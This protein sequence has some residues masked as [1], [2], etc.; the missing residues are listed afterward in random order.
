MPHHT[1]FNERPECQDRLIQFLV[2]MGY[3]Y[4]PRGEAEKKRAS[5]S[6][7]VFEDEVINFLKKQTYTFKN[8]EYH[9]SGESIR[10]AV[11]GLDVSLL[12]GL[13]LAGKEIYHMLTLGV[14]VEENIVVDRD[15]PIRQSFDLSFIDFE[16]PL[17]NTWQVTE[18][19]SVERPNGSFARPDIV[20]LVNGIP[21]VVIECKKSG[22]DVLAGVKQNIRNMQPDYI[23]QLF[24]FAQIVLALNPNKGLYGTSGSG[25][26][27]FIEWKEENLEW[28]KELCQ[29][30]SPDREILEQDRVATSLLEKT[31]LL[32]II[33]HFILYDSNIKK[34]VRHQQYFAIHAAIK[35]IDGSDGKGSEETH[36]GGVIWHTQ[37][38]GKSL[39]MIMLVKMI[40]A[41]KGME[42]PRFLMVTDRVNLDKQIKENFV[43]SAMV[44]SHAATGKGLKGLLQDKSNT[45]ITTLL[46]KFVTVCKN[47]Y[48]AVDSDKFYIFV[49]EAHRSQ[50]SS[51]Y[52]YM[53]EV[54]PNATIIGFTGTPLI[55][56]KKKN[57][58]A[59]FGAGIHSYTM[60]KGIEDKIIVPLVYEGRVVVQNNPQSTIDGFFD[61]MTKDLPKEHQDMLKDR[62]S[63]FKKL[64]E[65]SSR[66]NLIAWDISEHFSQYCIPKNQ[67]AM[68]A[69]SSRAA[70]VDIFN[71]LKSIN[72]PEI[73]PAVVITFGDKAEG[74]SDDQSSTAISKINAYQ[75][76]YVKPQFGENVDAYEDSVCRQFSNPDGDVNILLVKDKLLTGF[77]AP[78]AGVLYIDKSMKEHNLLQAIARVNRVY[79][80]KD[81]GLVVDYWGVFSHLKSAIDMYDDAESG[82]SNFDKED[83]ADTIYGPLDEKKK[84]EEAHQNIWKL[85][86]HLPKKA[87][88]NQYQEALQEEA[89]RK[90]FYEKLKSFATL[91][92]LAHVN[93]SIFTAIGIDKL[94]FYQDEYSFFKK[95]RESVIERYDD[96]LDFSQYESGIKA[97]LDTFVHATEIKVV[98]QPIS[99]MDE[100]AMDEL[101]QKMDSSNSS[102][103][104]TAGAKAD[105]IKT[106]IESK[107]KQIR[108]DDPLLFEEFSLKIKNTLA[109]YAQ[110]RDNDAYFK[111]MDQMAQDFRNGFTT[112]D[113]PSSI[114]NDGEAKAFYGVFLTTIPKK[115]NYVFNLV[116][117]EICA[118]YALQIKDSIMQ[119]T[120][121]DWK[122]NEMAHK[123]I[124]RLLDNALF[125][126]FDD[127]E[128]VV[129]K[130]NVDVVD[131]LIDE[132]MKVA[133][134]KF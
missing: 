115:M 44:V 131:L 120:K 91:L 42:N 60:K 49:D 121:R 87:S 77:D 35:R 118:K 112:Q 24:K 75:S 4:I 48:L 111:A 116:S 21:L 12:Q 51:M 102:R 132:I 54:L 122:H 19:F 13:T 31:R 92:N 96:I 17:N 25:A 72:N 83:I 53:R 55:A 123:A 124:H 10:K 64:A 8:Q 104:E 125:E 9:F 23:P 76:K 94:N 30:C 117:E 99:I 67:K 14:S 119:N 74:D 1:I 69:C 2:N 18:E 97:L 130:D 86:E 6:K 59:R 90:E 7:V 84:L 82:F 93:R 107:L 79:K 73:K 45:I 101:F 70:A 34:I 50:Y 134:A 85:F 38:S 98:V 52:T 81:F 127:L 105:A 128:I 63:R 68:I 41:K 15:M 65:V 89:T 36:N 66:L 109:E 88:A 78:V 5:L 43:N 106:R 100:K 16:N 80:E 47:K 95:L 126:M 11:V 20:L 110:S 57:T 32:D 29:K 129:D 33:E 27:F 46:H 108:Y 114:K 133:V 71:A 58:Y 37:G 26:D 56:K 103:E 39:T 62:Y 28:Q 113:Y 61:N 3:E 22:V 40:Q